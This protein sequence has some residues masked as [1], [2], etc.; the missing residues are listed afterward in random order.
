MAFIDHIDSA[1][2]DRTASPSD[3]FYRHV[4]GGWLAANPVPA[5]YPAWGAAY[6]VHV[7]NEEALHRILQEAADEEAA[8]GTPVQMVGDYFAAGMDE[9][10][11]AAAD[12]TPLESYLDIISS[13]VDSK[14]LAEA[15]I[16]LHRAGV[17]VFH[18]LSVAS[19]FDDANKYLVYLGQ[20][21][22]G[23][24]ERDYYLRDDDRSTALLA[25]YTD[26]VATQLTNL[27][28]SDP[29]TAA[30][31]VV[32]LERS[33]ARASLPAEKLRD[34]K[35]TL[36]RHRVDELDG[37]MPTFRLT[38]YMRAH[39]VSSD[40]VNID[41][42]A[43]FI[44]LETTLVE[45]DMSVVRSYLRW[46]L[47]RKYASSLSSKFDDAAFDFYGRLLGG[48][49][50]QRARWQRVLGS[51]S[52]D[53]GEQVSR[54]YVDA[55]FSPE[56]K[57]RCEEMVAGLVDAM[58]RSIETLEWMADDTR[59]AAL[60]KVDSFGYKIGYPDEWRDYTGLEIGSDSFAANRIRCEIF[61]HERQFG[62]LDQPVD[63]GEWEMPAHVVNAYYHPL[64]NEIVFPAGILQPPFFYVDADDALIYGGIGTVIGHEI[65][66]GFDDQGSQFDEMG[67][68]RS[69]WSEKD[70]TEFERRAEVLVEQFSE[71][72]VVE[73]Q[74][75]NGRLTLG[76]NIADLGGLK[77]AF[78]AFV[79]TL[80]GDETEIG[81]FT[82]RQR[83]FV[84]Y[85][86]IW[87][88]NYTEQYA[89]MLA[90]VDV[91]SPSFVRV[92]GPL[93]NFPPFAEAFSLGDSASMRVDADDRVEIW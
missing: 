15:L 46:Q 49:Q 65:T 76:E 14:T 74:K 67:R 34:R 21:G 84:S 6:E 40:T 8:E 22:L 31:Q 4:N 38:S 62:R 43:F 83:F 68:F 71:Y 44:A 27:G 3:D 61:E 79:S 58:R 72:D 17:G 55:E 10:S 25:A 82:P 92:N 9:A 50:T 20:G 57:R 75:L 59:E 66:H 5:E 32:A 90:N 37:L 89:R 88:T 11:I 77:I 42:P 64:L 81:G 86:T 18:S 69:W 26:H 19:D 39:G 23:L 16:E 78:D 73:D 80:D 12:I 52:A 51:A 13:V 1:D 53:I 24:P 30:E 60:T 54:L 93:S 56:A 33:L 41:H 70:R 29:E 63:R 7:R 47:V 85:A 48:Q 35:L 2:F 87:R 28:D 91:H 36:N 45:T